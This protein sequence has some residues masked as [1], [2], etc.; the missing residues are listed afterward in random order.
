M[1]MLGWPNENTVP[2]ALSN[3][4]AQT[5]RLNPT[6]PMRTDYMP[7]KTGG[8]KFKNIVEKQKY[9][10]ELAEKYG[11]GVVGFTD[12]LE[13]VASPLPP[14]KN[15]TDG[16]GADAGS[17][18]MYTDPV[19]YAAAKK[20]GVPMD[21]KAEKLANELFGVFEKIR[22]TPSNSPGDQ[23]LSYQYRSI[24]GELE[25][26]AL[27]PF[28]SKDPGG[29]S[30]VHKYS[31]RADIEDPALSLAV[32]MSEG[33]NQMFRQDRPNYGLSGV[34]QF[35]LDRIVERIP[36]FVKKGYLPKDFPSKIDP[37]TWKNEKGESVVTSNFLSYDDVITAQEAFIKAAK[38]NARK[39]AQ[40][41]NVKLTPDALDYFTA[42]GHN[43]GEGNA[44]EMMKY[45]Q[46]EGLL[47]GDKFLEVTPEKYKQPDKQAKERL[48]RKKM[49]IGEG[50]VKQKPSIRNR[51]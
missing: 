3:G 48:A 51:P 14:V 32:M 2:P 31:K 24:M 13:T 9:W 28:Q 41:L 36:E 42:V 20:A 39:T 29:Q 11:P 5:F 7:E 19:T 26:I 23:E 34:K 22:S 18:E 8:R 44:R 17:V 16:S 33:G 27:E 10:N 21:P 37:Y 1:E 46:S 30:L 25:K 6:I 15:F 47:G 35:G 43:A 40:Q 4:V 38:D 12:I 49:L 50:V 45:F